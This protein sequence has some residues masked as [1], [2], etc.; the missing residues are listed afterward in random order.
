MDREWRDTGADDRRRGRAF[1]SGGA[2]SGSGCEKGNRGDGA[3]GGVRNGGPGKRGLRDSRGRAGALL[4]PGHARLWVVLSEGRLSEYRAGPAGRARAAEARVGLCRIPEEH[5][6]DRIRLARSDAGACVPAV[7]RHSQPDRGRRGAARGRRGR[8]LVLAKRRGDSPGDRIGADC[9]R[10]GARGRR[11][12][13]RGESWSLRDAFAGTIR[14]S[15]RRSGY[16][17]WA[18]DAG[19]SAERHFAATD[20]EPMVLAA[21]GARPLV[22]SRRRTSAGVGRGGRSK[23]SCERGLKIHWAEFRSFESGFIP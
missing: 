13:R 12:L 22:S 20:G 9:R 6:T 14:E 15:A 8:R 19:E 10:C 23:V 11:K 16:G 2:V 4:L 17:G 21:R 18:A 3:G 7:A 5:E 1:L